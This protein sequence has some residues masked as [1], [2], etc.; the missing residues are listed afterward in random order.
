M[1]GGHLYLIIVEALSFAL[2][3]R[4]REGFDKLSPNGLWV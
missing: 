3:A 1:S 2:A 4:K